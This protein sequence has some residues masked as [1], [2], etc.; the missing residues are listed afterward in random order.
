TA[1]GFDPAEIATLVRADRVHRR[2]FTEPAV[3]HQ[4]MAQIFGRAWVYVGHEGE[5][6][7]PGDYKRARIGLEPVIMIRGRDGRIRIFFNSCRHRAASLCQEER[8]NLQHLLCPYHGWVYDTAGA[9]VSVPFQEQQSSDFERGD[10]PLLQPP[11]VASRAGFWFAC[12]DDAV[13]PLD[14]YLGAAGKYLDYFVE[15]SPSGRIRLDT[16]V[17]KYAYPG[18]WKAQVENS[19]DGY[20]PAL[21]HSSF[22]RE[23]L[24]ERLGVDATGMVDGTSPVQARAFPN[25]HALNDYR[26][27]DRGAILGAKSGGLPDAQQAHRQAV[28]ERLGE[29]R[30]AEVLRANGADG[31]NLLVFPNLVLIGVQVRVIQPISPELTEVYAA[32]ALL[33]NV[34]EELN[35][36]RLRAHE[37]FYGPASFGA[38]DDVE[39][40]V[41]QWQGLQATR[42]EWLL[43]ERGMETEQSDAEGIYNQCA[44]ETSLR[45]IWRRYREL[46]LAGVAA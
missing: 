21:V 35:V 31:Y 39:M 32:P 4:E 2:V 3:F 38:P 19:M 45:G 43:Y 30:G 34:P 29:T 15:L 40:F 10:Y 25:G 14:D 27:V 6:P 9:L 13:E 5:L 37:D 8:G 26:M 28:I 7:E 23:V 18:N 16:G 41:R 46:M 11:R 1:G 24:G 42:N 22:F 17:H 20:H 12:M 33:E 36:A 44:T